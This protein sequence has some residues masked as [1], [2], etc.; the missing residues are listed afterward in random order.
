MISA[1]HVVV[2]VSCW[3]VSPCAVSLSAGAS[4][5]PDPPF[6]RIGNTY[7]AQLASKT[8]EEGRAYWSKLGLIIGGGYDLHYDWD[9]PHWA[10]R[11]ERVE[12]NLAKLRRV[13][14]RILVL[15]Y[16]D[17]I[18]GPDNSRL[19]QSWWDLKEGKRWSG[20]PEYF[21]V[22]T[23]LP[24]VLQFNLDQVRSKILSR[25]CF[26]GVFYDCWGPDPW[27]VPKTAALRGGR[28]IVMINDW[29]LP[30]KGFAHLNGCLAEDE[31]NRVIEGKVDFEEFLAR[32]L[33][34]CRESRKPVVTMLV[35]HPQSMNTDPWYWHSLPWKQRLEAR[36]KLQHAD[37]KTMRFGLCTTLMGDGYFGYD[38]ANNGRG[39]WW[40]YPEYD[41]PLGYPRG[42]AQRNAD[43]TWQRR[44]DGGLVVVN[45][46]QYDA[47]VR[48][49]ATCRDVSTGRVARQFTLPMIDGRILVPSGEPA[50]TGDDV[51]PR[52]TCEPAR[53]LRVVSLD[54]RMWAVQVPGGLELRF[55]GDGALRHI[56]WQGRSLFGGGWPVVR[57]IEHGDFSAENTG[58]PQIHSGDGQADLT[59]QGTLV[60]GSQR[61]DYVETCVVRPD[62]SFSLEFQFTA[63]TDLK[64]RM[65]R[66]Y[67]DF[68]AAR[69]VGATVR[70]DHGAVT[71]PTTTAKRPL[72]P[73]SRTVTVESGEFVVHFESSLPLATA[74]D[75]AYKGD[76]FLLAGYPVS[77]AVKSGTQWS[78]RIRTSVSSRAKR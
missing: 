22:N 69:Y 11:L 62:A 40:W 48:T 13:N 25:Q 74:D 2:A 28:A 58:T 70:G 18:Q 51:P 41:A 44:F 67:F 23:R 75:R 59:F 55:A 45:G 5:R 49:E 46:S 3:A 33:R 71:L 10:K 73:G 7:A 57:S 78:V 39:D 65:W 36:G 37:L 21:R 29:N 19:P 72:L 9:D 66:H 47:I 50:T 53:K 34:W 16:V 32:Y 6:P 15:P 35:G 14:P 1:F 26:D 60:S 42:P 68:P 4:L 64:L 43:G 54:E 24:E 8:W 30:R 27:L 61:V 52:I 63:R 20:W 77:G 17:V 56:L 31:F 12:A 38:C 76:K